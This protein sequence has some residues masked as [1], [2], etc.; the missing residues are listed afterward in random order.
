MKSVAYASRVFVFGCA[1]LA[2]PFIPGVLAGPG[3]ADLA[4]EIKSDRVLN[5]PYSAQ[6]R[7]TSVEKRTDGVSSATES[8]G[9]DARDSE[10]RTFTSGERH[11]IYKENGKSVL[12]S[13]MLY[14][15]NDPIAHTTTAWDSS[16]RVAK[17]VKWP[18]ET[19]EGGAE[20]TCQSACDA[21]LA[22]S[23]ESGLED[24]G[25]RVIEG[26][27]V[28]GKRSTYSVDAGNVV[29]EVWFSP[30]LKVVILETND[31]P[32]TGSWRNELIGISR[33]KPE[34]ALF[35]PPKDYLVQEITFPRPK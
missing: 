14:R 20:Q 34:A 7:F 5:L 3:R 2:L 21:V 23:S 22:F 29:H 18:M 17:V 12:K 10:G 9:N 32:R 16:S 24:I 19:T 15:V 13:V 25:R 8:R 30:E 28:E 31:D 27:A 4:I 35:S 26:L 33:K 6:R 11:W 1:L